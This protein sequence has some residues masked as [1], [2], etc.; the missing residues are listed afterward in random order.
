LCKDGGRIFQFWLQKQ[1]SK[2]LV[3]AVAKDLRVD[4]LMIPKKDPKEYRGVYVHTYLMVNIINWVSAEYAF[5]LTK[6]FEMDALV[7][8]M[9]DMSIY[10][11]IKRPP[12]ADCSKTYTLDDIITLVKPVIVITDLSKSVKKQLHGMQG[13]VYMF[14]NKKTNDYYIGSS[15]NIV[16]R[17]SGYL[18]NSYL[19]TPST[20]KNLIKEAMIKYGKLAFVLLIIELTITPFEREKHYIDLLDPKYNTD[21]YKKKSDSV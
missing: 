7:K 13:G 3:S 16:S 21:L 8:S 20:Y 15:K 5:R 4:T 19:T 17:V 14:F 9:Q 18:I 12:L 6:A 11:K 2:D 1:K 10:K